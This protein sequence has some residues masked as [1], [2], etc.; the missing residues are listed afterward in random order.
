MLFKLLVE[1]L[2][3]LGDGGIEFKL[4]RELC[5]FCSALMVTGE[6]GPDKV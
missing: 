4:A 6:G 3:I 1:T 2:F 5:I